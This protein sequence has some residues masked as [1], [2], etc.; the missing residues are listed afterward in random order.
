[1]LALKKLDDFVQTEVELR[2]QLKEAI[3]KVRETES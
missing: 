1:M 3:A 2:E